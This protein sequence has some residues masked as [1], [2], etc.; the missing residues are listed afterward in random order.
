MIT[1]NRARRKAAKARFDSKEYWFL[2]L[3]IKSGM[4]QKLLDL[5]K[6]KRG[7]RKSFHTHRALRMTMV[8]VMGAIRG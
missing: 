4:V 5:F 1:G 3:N 2:K 6:T 8:A 7:R